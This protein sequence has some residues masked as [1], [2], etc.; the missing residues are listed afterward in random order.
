MY[1]IICPCLL[2]SQLLFWK[3]RAYPNLNNSFFFFTTWNNCWC[4]IISACT[5]KKYIG[6]WK[7]F[8][9]CCLKKQETQTRNFKLVN[10]LFKRKKKEKKNSKWH[11]R[12]VFVIFDLKIFTIV[13]FYFRWFILMGFS[14]HFLAVLLI[15]YKWNSF[16]SFKK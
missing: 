1:L 11:L 2:A 5:I 8:Y 16:C 12:N 6:V 10:R 3:G 4:V 9:C 14:Q 15:Y 13:L 7:V